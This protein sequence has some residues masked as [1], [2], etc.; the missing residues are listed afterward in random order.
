MYGHFC[1]KLRVAFRAFVPHGQLIILSTSFLYMS[2]ALRLVIRQKFVTF[3]ISLSVCFARQK[4][5]L[6]RE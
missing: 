2:L 1:G 3:A 4:S 6:E 5:E